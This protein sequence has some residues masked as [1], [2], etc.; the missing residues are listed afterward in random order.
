[1]SVCVSVCEGSIS[2]YEADSIE[3]LRSIQ[4]CNH[5]SEALRMF[6]RKLPDLFLE[7]WP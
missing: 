3:S 2:L 1:M 5:I 4:S 7:Y 6:G